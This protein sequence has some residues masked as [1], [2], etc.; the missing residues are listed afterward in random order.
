MKKYFNLE[1]LEN[2]AR[3]PYLIPEIKDL[4]D[5]ERWLIVSEGRK[6]SM[7]WLIFTPK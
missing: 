6:L 3:N 1:I 7:N 2:G 4:D 5:D